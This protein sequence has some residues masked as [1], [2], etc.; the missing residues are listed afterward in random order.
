MHNGN[1]ITDLTKTNMRI[2][3]HYKQLYGN[4]FNTLYKINE[5]L[6]KQ[7]IQVE[8]KNYNS[9]IAIKIIKS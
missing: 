6:Q 9:S 7:V 3:R 8:L 5:F 2:R 4:N 1:I